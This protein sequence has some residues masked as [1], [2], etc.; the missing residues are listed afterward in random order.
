[1]PRMQEICNDVWKQVWYVGN[2][3]WL[4]SSSIITNNMKSS[5]AQCSI[6]GISIVP[7]QT[8]ETEYNA[9][10]REVHESRKTQQSAEHTPSLSM[11]GR[12]H[13]MKR[14]MS[15]EIIA[16]MNGPAYNCIRMSAENDFSQAYPIDPVCSPYATHDRRS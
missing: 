8:F 14:I 15:P 9:V 6:E 11:N 5:N 4:C 16:A 7:G 2:R 12:V 13:Q 10:S 3:Y 1:M